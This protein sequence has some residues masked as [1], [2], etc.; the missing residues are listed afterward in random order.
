MEE[1]ALTSRA[2]EKEAAAMVAQSTSGVCGMQE[3]EMAAQQGDSEIK[4]TTIFRHAIAVYPPIAMLAG[5]QLDIFTPLEDG[6]ITATAL[7]EQLGVRAEKLGPLLYALVNA[8][9]LTVKEERFENTPEAAAYL[10][11]GRPA[12][13]GGAHE[14]Y[15]D[16]WSAALRTAESLRAG[17]DVTP[18]VHPAEARVSG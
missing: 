2:P 16:L 12:Y 6:P 7:A 14:L 9:L 18:I 15:S 17:A 10:V 4:P 3:T 11:R 8:E 5:M 13:I 1:A